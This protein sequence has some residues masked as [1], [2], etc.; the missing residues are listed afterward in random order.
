MSTE[1]PPTS[2]PPPETVPEH[3]QDK[4]K[5][6]S[7]KYL[8]VED[9]AV[10]EKVLCH[11]GSLI[12]EAK[13]LQIGIC[14]ETRKPEYRIH[15]YGWKK[16]YDEWVPQSR[17][18][19]LNEI[20]LKKKR[21]LEISLSKAKESKSKKKGTNTKSKKSKSSD[22]SSQS[23]GSSSS[24]QSSSNSQRHLSADKST[25]E[26]STRSELKEDKVTEDLEGY[27]T[28][29]EESKRRR[30]DKEQET[31]NEGT[32][33]GEKVHINQND[34]RSGDAC[35]VDL[36]KKRINKVYFLKAY[37][38]SE[39]EESKVISERRS[40]RLSVK[41][42]I[43]YEE[44]KTTNKEKYVPESSQQKFL[45][46][47][48]QKF[49][50]ENEPSC[51][52]GQAE[53]V[54]PIT[55][56]K[57][58]YSLIVGKALEKT[59]VAKIRR[60]SDKSENAGPSSTETGSDK[61]KKSLSVNTKKS[62]SKKAQTKSPATSKENVDQKIEPLTFPTL[63][64]ELKTFLIDDWDFMIRQ[65]KLCFL[66]VEYTVEKICNHFIS[67]ESMHDG[68][69]K[70]KVCHVMSFVQHYFDAGLEKLLLF[71]NEQPQKNEIKE[72]HPTKKMSEIY[73]GTHLV[74]LMS[75]FE[76][77]NWKDMGKEDFD[78]FSKV[79]KLFLEYLIQKLEEYCYS[80]YYIDFD[81]FHRLK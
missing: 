7:Y 56:D 78:Y 54:F 46:L 11:Q 59:A 57:L 9:I 75:H 39:Y 51:S 30:I 35:D 77:K 21:E 41:P 8:V 55:E 3:L 70:E 72:L 2:L 76:E 36:K 37:D 27:D 40:I 79:M 61:P 53:G 63:P 73:G 32:T 14:K 47:I 62:T 15:Y 80:S 19:K 42:R 71:K 52:N 4:M 48:E 24:S 34:N 38:A 44:Q 18:L 60:T 28:L 69:E 23:T 43:T 1:N 67:C 20:N 66:P 33:N 81:H 13:I 5:D 12:Y 64:K 29:D 74:R 65:H 25:P 10:G 17:I 22:S 50:A 58:K 68:V 6:S 49:K 31:R 26:N 16:T 45:N